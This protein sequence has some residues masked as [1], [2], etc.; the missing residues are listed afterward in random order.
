ML[1]YYAPSRRVKSTSK[2]ELTSTVNFVGV[3]CPRPFDDRFRSRRA[4]WALTLSVEQ[5]FQAR[6][7]WRT[8]MSPTSG[9]AAN[10]IEI[11]DPR[12]STK[13]H[14]GRKPL[15][16]LEKKTRAPSVRWQSSN[17]SSKARRPP[18]AAGVILSS[19]LGPSRC[20]PRNRFSSWAML[21]VRPENA[22]RSNGYA[23]H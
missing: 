3:F 20:S 2:V 11:A 4:S 10:V 22:R 7:R 1:Q 6:R 12:L 16:A 23:R 14:Q 17:A 5:V 19:G 18:S 15:L 21:L 9:F 13:A 8:R